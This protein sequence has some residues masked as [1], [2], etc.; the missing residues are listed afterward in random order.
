M[1][2][3]DRSGPLGQGPMTGRQLGFC[4]DN[5]GVNMYR[6]M[7]GGFG[8]GR[9]MGFRKN[10]QR[11][12]ESYPKEISIESEKE[13]LNRQVKSLKETLSKVEERLSQIDNAAVVEKK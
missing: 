2:G 7:G 13:V 4:R 5:Q 11:F 8:R 1:P 9:G 10:F 6:Q 12:S 3:G